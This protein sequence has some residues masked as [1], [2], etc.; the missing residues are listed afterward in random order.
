MRGQHLHA[1]NDAHYRIYTMIR[2]VGNNKNHYAIA[3][4]NKYS[5]TC[6]KRPP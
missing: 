5:G 4:A 6:L 2:M 3:M 1:S